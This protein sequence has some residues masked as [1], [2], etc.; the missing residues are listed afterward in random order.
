M[1]RLFF[2]LSALV[3]FRV[4]WAVDV[5][6]QTDHGVPH[7]MVDGK[8][9]RQRWF[10]GNQAADRLVLAPGW[11]E[12]SAHYIPTFTGEHNLTFHLRFPHQPN[13]FLLEYYEVI[14]ETAGKPLVPR[15]DFDGQT[16]AAPQGW[17][18]WPTDP[19]KNTVGV[20]RLVENASSQ[21]GAAWRITITNPRDGGAWPDFHLYTE[22]RRMTLEEGHLYAIRFRIWAKEPANVIPGAYEPASPSYIP[23]FRSDYLHA[24]T[25]FMQQIRLAHAAGVD[26]ITTIVP[27]PWERDGVATDWGK[28]DAVMD[29]VLAAN[30]QALIVPRIRLDAPAW[31]LSAHP[32]ETVSWREPQSKHGITASISSQVWLQDALDNLV[33]CIRH[34]ENRYP[35]RIAGYHPCNLNTWEWFYQ[36][37]WREDFHGY[38]PA[39][40]LGFR[41]WL[42]RH[43]GSDTA[44]Q[45][46][47]RDPQATIG[48]AE[49]P[50]PAERRN[51]KTYVGFLVP[52]D[53]QRVIDHN[54]FLQDAISEAM[55]EVAKTVRHAT[56]ER[57]LVVFFYGYI[58]EFANMNRM[59][60]CGHLAMN[61]LLDSPDI[62][63]L[64]SPI[65]YYDRLDG[66]S[67]SSMTCAESVLLHDKL[68][69]YED[70]TRT[71]LA[72]NG[73][74]AGLNEY[75]KTPV[76]SYEVL[77]RNNAQEIIRNLGCWWMDLAATG[78]YN[79]PKLWT[80][81][82]ALAEMEQA[83][84]ANPRPYEPPIAWVLDECSAIYTKDARRITAPSIY[85]LRAKLA[86]CGAPFGQY[87]L[88]DLLAGL[89]KSRLVIV[90]NVQICNDCQRLKEILSDRFVLWVH[91]PG[92]IDPERGIDLDASERLTGFRISPLGSGRQKAALK[93]TALGRQ[94]GFPETWNV[95]AFENEVFAVAEQ[96]GDEVLARWSNGAAAVVRRGDALFSASPALP[97]ELLRLAAYYAGVHLYTYDECVLYTDGEYLMLHGVSDGQINLRFPQPTQ[98]LNVVYGNS[99][100]PWPMNE[101]TMRLRKG[102]T[103]VFQMRNQR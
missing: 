68:W 50:S 28:V 27:M 14:D 48:T 84:L 93:A 96:P 38:S 102:E 16:G 103:Q 99:L 49:P 6:L 33:K 83:K 72:A 58:C 12:V 54:C 60:A 22:P 39:E 41:D 26:F 78:W 82:S 62:D 42:R 65:S 69:L 67:G 44:L 63:I 18:A 73:S 3:M 10:W 7:I 40:I 66:G 37:S 89:V 8:A 31:W 15:F 4:A 51:A 29:E 88:D 91:A 13:E 46:A 5:Y 94:R 19:Q 25:V 80:A 55:K 21:G 75:V 30:P 11:Q 85:E 2:V 70:D 34:L 9:V 95:A 90:G 59:S 100:P 76:A 23:A 45:A 77:L 24:D 98:L 32:D 53:A 57:R 87:Y 47:W 1:K 56:S 17:V 79:D 61:Q 52:G 35:N 86:R 43:Y 20:T 92:I 71:Y 81:N 64:C 36:D 101:L 74:L 97:R